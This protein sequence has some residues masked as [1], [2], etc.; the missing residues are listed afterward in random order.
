[1]TVRCLRLCALALVE[2]TY[3]N[4]PKQILLHDA[5]TGTTTILGAA[6]TNARLLVIFAA[7]LGA[8]AA[9]ALPEPAP[10]TG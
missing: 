9:A 10:V 2:G 4:D 3:G 5:L 6:I 1:V 8:G 7:A